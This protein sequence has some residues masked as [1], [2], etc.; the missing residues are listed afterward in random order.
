[1]KIFPK[2]TPRPTLLYVEDDETTRRMVT[3]LIKSKLP[4]VVLITAV[5]GKAGLAAFI[6]HE[7]DLVIADVNMPEMDGIRMAGEMKKL[8]KDTR[9][10]VTTAN[11]DTSRI[12]EAIDIGINHYVLKP[13]NH[14]KLLS[15]I[16]SC[17]TGIDQERQISEQEQFIRLLSRAVE[18]SPVAIMITD[19]EGTIE[20]VNPGFSRLTGYTFA[21]AMGQNAR[22]LK[23]GEIPADVY[24]T[25]WETITAGNEWGGELHNRTKSEKLYW[26]SATISP[27]TDPTG[28]ITHF[29][30]FQEDITERKQA[31]E[32]IRQMAY[33]D[34][35]TGLPNRHFF[36]ELLNSALA[37]ARRHNRM[38][39]VLFLDLDHFKYVNDTHGHPVGDQLLQATAQ[40]LRESC[41]RAGDTVARRGGDEFIILLP[42]LDDPREPVRVAQ[43][44]IESFALPFDLPEHELAISTSVGIS[45]FP[46][47]GDDPEILIRRADIAMYRAKEEGRNRYHLY[48]PAM[49]S[50]MREEP[51]LPNPPS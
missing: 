34:A 1:M 12:L 26:A 20:Y 32:T 2:G 8:H 22:V 44:I 25:L 36:Q 40:R 51:R 21:E 23:S 27:V 31:E 14:A 3:L 5:N 46:D 6:H 15:A 35:L 43:R 11:S 17:L 50:P 41:R 37:Q 9:I 47:D 28:K 29:I 13:I 16:S 38:L 19:K 4:E 45:I 10:I 48:T 33:F 24:K 42:E 7:P 49:D 18:Q 39:A 30:A